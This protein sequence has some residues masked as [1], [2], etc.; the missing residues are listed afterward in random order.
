MDCHHYQNS[1]CW[2]KAQKQSWHRQIHSWANLHLDASY[3]LSHSKRRLCLMCSCRKWRSYEKQGTSKMGR[4]IRYMHCL[5]GS[6]AFPYHTKLLECLIQTDPNSASFT[7]YSAFL[8]SCWNWGKFSPIG[9][10]L[11]YEVMKV[12]FIVEPR[13]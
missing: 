3:Y 4:P 5:T 1:H 9:K 10:S 2:P 11:S 6:D 8:L 12:D 7:K 13:S